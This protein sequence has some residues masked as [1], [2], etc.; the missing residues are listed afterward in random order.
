VNPQI[1]RVFFVFAFLFLALIGA[2]T[3]WLWRAPDL[4]ARQGNPSLIVRQLTIK[5][6]FIYAADGTTVLAGRRAVKLQDGRTWYVRRYPQRQL[7]AHPVGY[8]TIERARTEL[9]ESLNDF[10]TGSNADLSTVVDNALDKFQ[11]IT[12]EGNDVVTT[13]RVEPQRVAME[14]LAGKCGAAVAIEPA[15]GRILALA[16]SPSYN[17]NLVDTDFGAIESITAPCRPAA[18]LVNRGT[19]GLFIPGSTF[20]VVTAAAALDTGRFTPDSMFEDPG[21]CILFGQRVTNFS[22][23]SGPQVF[24]QLSLFEALENSVN[25]VFCNIGKELGAGTVLEYAQRFGFY[26]RPPVEL[27]DD[28]VRRSG[29]YRD[30]RLYLPEDPSEVDPGRLAFGQER[31]LVTPLQNA[32]VAAGIANDGVVMEP[33][34]VERIVSPDGDVID[35]FDPNDWK[36]AVKPQTAADL[37][38]MMTAVVESGTATSAQIPGVTVAGKTGTAETGREG[39]NDTWFI[40]FAPVEDP[41]VAVA[42]ALSDQSGTG[43]G[44]A[45]PIAREIMAAVLKGNP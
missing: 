1:R 5:R 2:A 30:G 23:Q 33:K 39:R 17:P 20:K 24:G 8:S 10:L 19:A 16:S 41:Q 11:G 31:L 3:Y 35:S 40:G 37:Q 28:D 44:T 36:T 9:E 43:G 22:D 29:L 18:P 6:G 34:L 21:F 32:L 12:Q 26:D 38:A 7:T 13:L 15:T 25:S 14:Q 4:E 45:A 27:P 42:V